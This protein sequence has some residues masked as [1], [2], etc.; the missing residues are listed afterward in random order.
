MDTYTIF[1][2]YDAKTG[3]LPIMSAIRKMFLT[4]EQNENPKQHQLPGLCGMVMLG[5]PFLTVNS[6]EL[7]EKIFTPPL[8]KY[9]TKNPLEKDATHMLFKEAF[10]FKLSEDKDFAERRKTLSSSLF[11]D[12]LRLMMNQIKRVCMEHIREHKDKDEFDIV[13]FF[14]RLQGKII[15]QFGL[16]GDKPYDKMFDYEE[17][18]GTIKSITM[19]QL[20][21]KLVDDLGERIEQPLQFLFPSLVKYSI[22]AHDKRLCILQEY[23]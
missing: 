17:A 18:D 13:D 21:E 5:N 3:V 16:G 1:S 23:Q 2:L 6:P 9:V 8:S 20:F 22:G 14:L 19:I 15:I 4:A 11:K 12:K 7:F 10:F